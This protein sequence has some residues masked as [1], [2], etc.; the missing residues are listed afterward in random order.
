[1]E[2]G[3]SCQHISVS[4]ALIFKWIVFICFYPPVA[5]ALYENLY[6]LLAYKKERKKKL[7]CFNMIEDEF[8]FCEL[9][10]MWQQDQNIVMQQ[11]NNH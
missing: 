1:M 3:E 7:I 8:C 11:T 10:S 2:P 5:L 4:A 6:S 9:K